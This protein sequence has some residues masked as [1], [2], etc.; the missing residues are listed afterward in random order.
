M[1]RAH[2]GDVASTLRRQIITGFYTVHDKLP[3]ERHLA[4][5][6]NISR[7]TLREAL[8]Q[9]EQTGLV[10]RRAGSGTYVTYHKHEQPLSVVE[11][12]R[13]IELMDARFALEP[14]IAR[15]A[16]L[17]ANEQ[18]L[19]K[20]EQTLN[21]MEKAGGDV[22]IF[23]Q[24]DE[25][26]HLALA[27]STQNTLLIWMM[28]QVS[29]VRSHAQWAHMRTLTLS[30]SMISLYNQQHRSILEAIRK[31]QPEEAAQLVKKHLEEA[32]KSLIDA[33]IP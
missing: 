5:Q 22:V 4:D 6:M 23:A 15:L 7:G 17:H 31:R 19:A 26:F 18:D 3:S 11:T 33:T 20:I 27:H 16:V 25:A 8:R 2:A 9:L 30:D 12:A 10:E 13:P 21:I 28:E 14:H 24:G 32:R 29:T 1:T